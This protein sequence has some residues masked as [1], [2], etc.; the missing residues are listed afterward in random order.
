MNATQHSRKSLAFTLIELLVVIAIIAILA[1]MLLPALS[2]AKDKA[3]RTV[4]VNNQK[5]MIAA[6][7]MYTTDYKDALPYPNWGNVYQGWLYTPAGNL[8]PNI[9][10]APLLND[11]T[12][13]YKGG[14]LYSYMPNPKAYKCPMD[15]SN[16]KY[17]AQRD[18]KLST[19]IMN[20]AA[21]GY[22]TLTPPGAAAKITQI[23]SPMC[24]LMWEPDETLGNPP[25]G[26]F[27]YNDASSFPDKNEG[28][29]RL[30]TSGAII[31]ALAGH[32][33][34]I[35]FKA[36]MTEQTNTG[37]GLLWWNPLRAD[38]HG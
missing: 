33:Q 29:G 17:Y 34:F 19:Y 21:C 37:R 35:T 2:K 32:V 23:W 5:Q 6:V 13:A 10:V 36:F 11:P 22:G 4:C 25:I 16:G 1:A 8:P 38:G 31:Q 3:A 30:H 9:G 28:V 14:L 12:P 7:I 18:N 20:G 24:Y 15:R 26:A 27:A